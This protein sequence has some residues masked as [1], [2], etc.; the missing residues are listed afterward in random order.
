[1]DKTLKQVDNPGAY[2]RISGYQVGKQPDITEYNHTYN[3][4]NYLPPDH[5][6]GHVPLL[7]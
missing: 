2:R 1:M 6:H 5:R 4:E 3:I 7:Y